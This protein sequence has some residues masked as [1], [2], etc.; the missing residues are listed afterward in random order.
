MKSIAEGEDQVET[1]SASIESLTAQYEDSLN[2]P[3]REQRQS[4]NLA[5]STKI[6]GDGD[7]GAGVDS[8]PPSTQEAIPIQ[9]NVKP[10]PLDQNEETQ[11]RHWSEISIQ[12]VEPFT[13]GMEEAKG[14]PELST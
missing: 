5:S 14:F 7:S 13:A 4:Q 8:P 11:V 1:L 2:T 6:Q 9:S 12:D 3:S 10:W